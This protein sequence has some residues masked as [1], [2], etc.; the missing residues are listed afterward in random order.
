MG[1]LVKYMVMK[2]NLSY[3]EQKYTKFKITAKK[4]ESYLDIHFPDLEVNDVVLERCIFIFRRLLKYADGYDISDNRVTVY[5]EMNGWFC[6]DFVTPINIFNVMF[7][8]TLDIEC[9]NPNANLINPISLDQLLLNDE[10]FYIF[11]N[12]YWQKSFNYQDLFNIILEVSEKLQ[13]LLP[14]EMIDIILCYAYQ[15]R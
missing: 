15:K 11:C 4:C 1:E 13:F 5:R 3:L 7:Y 9:N 8:K 14:Y 12:G 10:D 6:K 2:N